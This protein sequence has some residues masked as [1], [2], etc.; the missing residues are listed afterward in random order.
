MFMDKDNSIKVFVVLERYL[1]DID[2]GAKVLAVCKTL[3]SAKKVM[4]KES[5]FIKNNFKDFEEYEYSFDGTNVSFSGKSYN[6]IV[7]SIE[8][9][10]LSD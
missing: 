9:K 3:D 8:E 2:E 7:I 5:E 6:Y 4:N 10:E 1:I